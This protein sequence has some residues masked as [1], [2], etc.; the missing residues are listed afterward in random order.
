MGVQLPSLEQ[1]KDQAKLMRGA[2][3]NKGGV[4]SYSEA[5]EIIARQYGYRN[6]NTLHAACGNRP[7]NIALKSGDKV[8]GAYLGQPFSASVIGVQ[9]HASQG[10][11]RVTL[12]F[13]APVD[14]VKFDSFS[15]FRQRVTCT[16]NPNG[17]TSERTSDGQP[18]V[19]LSA[20]NSCKYETSRCSLCI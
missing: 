5:L 16:L 12:H 13:D 17:R 6:W 11:L 1:L 18:Q 8:R 2:L 10:R 4:L 15:S 14:V 9:S 3:A 19:Q 7:V 20:V